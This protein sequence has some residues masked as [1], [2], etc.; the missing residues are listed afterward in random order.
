MGMTSAVS[1]CT[2]NKNDDR[3]F[4]I[5]PYIDIFFEFLEVN[6]I[7]VYFLLFFLGDVVAV[8]RNWKK[9]KREQMELELLQ[10]SFS[11][12]MLDDGDDDSIIFDENNMTDDD[13][14]LSLRLALNDYINQRIEAN[15]KSRAQENE[16]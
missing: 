4:E 5:P 6:R 2:G 14:K 10:D 12:D 9:V 1:I 11:L 8:Y 15:S 16:K 3:G 7:Y 13:K